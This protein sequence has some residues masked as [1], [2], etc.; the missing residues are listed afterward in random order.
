MTEDW[1][2]T[3]CTCVNY[4]KEVSCGW[5]HA[6]EL[7]KKNAKLERVVVAN[8]TVWTCSLSLKQDLHRWVQGQQQR[9]KLLFFLVILARRLR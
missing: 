1:H 3:E 6:D 5:A 8:Q 9:Q 7:I 4:S 2:Q